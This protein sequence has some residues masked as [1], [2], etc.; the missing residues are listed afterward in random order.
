MPGELRQALVGSKVL[1]IFPFARNGGRVPVRKDAVLD[2][3]NLCLAL[4][5]GRVAYFWRGK[6]TRCAVRLLKAGEDFWKKPPAPA[7]SERRGR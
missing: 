2:E 5:E 1:G 6:K 3:I 7:A 4:D